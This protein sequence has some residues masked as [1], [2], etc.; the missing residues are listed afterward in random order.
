MQQQIGKGVIDGLK[1]LGEETGKELVNQTGKIAETIITGK[2]LLGDIVPMSNQEMEKK[3][4]EE[5]QKKQK[6]M[7]D[8]KNQMSEHG[9]N[10]EGEMEQIRREKQQTE[11]EKEKA[12]LE[13]LKRQREEEKMQSDYTGYEESSNPNKRKKSRG[14]AFA[15]G[16]AKKE[17]MSQTREYVKKPD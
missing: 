17:D 5:E 10:V 4:V 13:N 6:E 2:E 8:L 15:G 7:A 9:R 1:Q 11:E 16:K 14:S 12:F 3:R